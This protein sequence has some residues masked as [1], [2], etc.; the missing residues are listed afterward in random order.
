[1]GNQITLTP[2]QRKV[3]DA[4]MKDIRTTSVLVLG[5]APGM[6]RTTILE[7]IQA[8]TGAGLIGMRQFLRTLMNREPATIEEA[9]LETVERAFEHREF[10]IV[11]D[12]HLV[13]GIV[14]WYDYPRRGLFNAAATALLDQIVKQDWKIL[15]GEIDDGES[16]AIERRGRAC[17]IEEFQPED[18]GSVFSAYLP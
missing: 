18:Y 7:E 12:L 13:R 1:M 15:F 16:G 11:D 8:S 9:F 10:V 3:A 17:K 2:S 14:D 5:C 4:L 6:G